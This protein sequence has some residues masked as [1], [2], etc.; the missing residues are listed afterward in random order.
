M[1]VNEQNKRKII[2]CLEAEDLKKD[3]KIKKIQKKKK[4]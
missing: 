3:I 4:Q 1:F 2:A